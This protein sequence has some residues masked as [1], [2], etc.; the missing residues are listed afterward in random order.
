MTHPPAPLR[1][2]RRRRVA[3]LAVALAWLATAVAPTAACADTPISL[4]RLPAAVT[5]T[6]VDYFPRSR[7]L[8]AGRDGDDAERSLYTVKV[9]YRAITLAVELTPQGRITDVVMADK[10]A[11]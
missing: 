10:P 3:A 11:R 6:L 9:R 2:H 7:N 8:S 1:S 5:K 4:D